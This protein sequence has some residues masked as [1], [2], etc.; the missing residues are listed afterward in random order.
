MR[1]FTKQ[2]LS[3]L[4]LVVLAFAPLTATTSAPAEAATSNYSFN[5]C[6]QEKGSAHVVLMMDESGSIYGENGTDPKNAR[7]SG[8]Q[9][10]LDNLQAVA[11]TYQKPINVQLAGFGD[12]FIARPEA[13]WIELQHGSDV[14]LKKLV[15][16]TKIWADRQKTKNWR[17][18]DLVSGMAGARDAFNTA[19]ADSCKLFVF[20]KDGQ[21]FHRF[22]PDSA[23][24]SPV[25]GY[26]EIDELLEARKFD[27]A[28]ELAVNEICRDGGLADALRLD[29]NLFSVGIGIS[30]GSKEQEGF[31]KFKAVI[32][33]VSTEGCK[34]GSEP[35]N[36]KYLLA[37]DIGDLPGQFCK[38]LNPN[39]PCITESQ[40][41]EL[42]LKRA[43][44]SI[45]VLSSGVTSKSF[46]LLPPQAC[47]APK[48]TFK[49]TEG[50]KI[51]VPI[52]TTATATVKWLGDDANQETMSLVLKQTKQAQMSCWEGKWKFMP[53]Q[54]AT[55][56]LTFDADLH[57][58]PK[59]SSDKPYVVP[60]DTQGTSYDINLGR[61]SET[62]NTPLDF[63]SLDDDISLTVNGLVRNIDTKESETKFEEFTLT[64]EQLANPRLLLAAT[65]QEFGN[66]ELILVLSVK[67][68][69][70]KY[71]LMP[72]TTQ[73]AFAVRSA[74][75]PPTIVG[76]ANFGT[77][78]GNERTEATIEI[79]GSDEEDYTVDFAGK[80]TQLKA[81]TFPEGVTYE[82]AF[83]PG[84]KQTF[85][86]PKG[87]T[88]EITV[89]VK[90]V[91]TNKNTN[92][93]IRAQMPIA[94]KIAISA[95]A[96]SETGTAVAIAGKFKADQKASS[97][98]VIRTL[99][100]LIFVLIG[101]GLSFLA[102]M[103]MSNY[104]SRLPKKDTWVQYKFVDVEFNGQGFVNLSNVR[105]QV[106][107]DESFENAFPSPNRR[108][109][110]F[111]QQVLE[112]KG[113][114]FDL[115]QVGHLEVPQSRGSV[116]I[117]SQN[118]KA[119]QLPLSLTSSWVFFTDPANLSVAKQGATVTGTALFVRL[120]FEQRTATDLFDEFEQQGGALLGELIAKAKV[121][122]VVQD[123]D[124]YS[125]ETQNSFGAETGSAP[126]PNKQP[127]FGKKP[128]TPE[129]PPATNNNNLDQW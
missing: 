23:E 51:D 66:Y 122:A 52:G 128:Q 113:N 49:A 50:E 30:S 72:I 16:S 95:T 107:S 65:D 61:P 123:R 47:S 108:Q 86:I 104:V 38:V 126:A 2:L 58:L 9:I 18:T 40:D 53:G 11:D 73:T 32:E 15:D 88:T 55:S 125:W 21:D 46:T 22:N 54:G 100:L 80:E 103:L 3:T 117:S 35:A 17:E 97:N 81:S 89:W 33:G 102:I 57:A 28:D 41:F 82:F 45:R 5:A 116:G 78:N 109:I 106:S 68:A 83:E 119:A 70:F 25:V 56:Y 71:E 8:A 96:A 62:N 19:P 85:N 29:K 87:K 26:P 105:S 92:G 69:G 43:L 60:G 120:K 110:T 79:M 44:A 36:G 124:G 111:G 91:S 75:T 48:I 1:K 98:S 90:A 77:L 101:I 42:E 64:G 20:F 31:K 59:F 34:G 6:V 14:N 93:E 118:H 76:E 121:A 84:E 63:G 127:L 12:N 27:K 37:D 10:L 94:G 115:S 39:N 112:R 7:I 74:K 129:A 99:L 4:G 114:G 24:A 13:G 67:V